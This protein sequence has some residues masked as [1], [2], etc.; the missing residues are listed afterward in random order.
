VIETAAFEG[1]AEA[2]SLAIVSRPEALSGGLVAAP[3]PALLGVS[4]ALSGRPR[5]QVSRA[6]DAVVDVVWGQPVAGER[7]YES[8]ERTPREALALRLF[9]FLAE[10]DARLAAE[11]GTGLSAESG[12]GLSAECDTGLREADVAV[13][14][15]AA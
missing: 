14:S 1:I 12:T 3:A 8:G 13:G 11:S 5:V 7:A 6:V 4:A 10:R 15:A 2:I 9:V